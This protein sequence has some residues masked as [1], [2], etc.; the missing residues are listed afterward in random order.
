MGLS[1][2]GP[3]AYLQALDR[4]IAMNIDRRRSARDPASRSSGITNPERFQPLHSFAQELLRRVQNEFDAERRDGFGIDPELETRRLSLP[5]VELTPRDPGSARLV[6]AFTDFPGLMMRCGY[7][8]VTAFPACGCDSCG[9]TAEGEAE[10]FSEIISA[11]TLGRFTES[12]SLP[13]IGRASYRYQLGAAALSSGWHRIERSRAR[14]ML[15]GRPSKIQWQ[16]WPRRSV[17]GGGL[18]ER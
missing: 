18:T 4:L 13:L 2:D 8:L 6:V 5:T 17:G 7:R 11:V 10:R 12:I 1:M 15:R 3:A 9:E 16:P 14:A